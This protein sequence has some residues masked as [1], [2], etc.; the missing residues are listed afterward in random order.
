MLTQKA[1]QR[2]LLIPAHQFR[3]AENAAPHPWEI[4]RKVEV[5]SDRNSAYTY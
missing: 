4:R 3:P 2:R 5:P 1:E